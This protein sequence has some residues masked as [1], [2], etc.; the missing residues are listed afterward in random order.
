MET[1]INIIE[2]ATTNKVLVETQF[3]RFVKA[4]AKQG[5]SK[6][7]KSTNTSTT[8][9]IVDLVSTP[10]PPYPTQITQEYNPQVPTISPVNICKNAMPKTLKRRFDQD[11]D[12]QAYIENLLKL[13][14]PIQRIT[15]K[16]PLIEVSGSR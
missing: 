12:F 9:N 11:G 3:R 5:R 14:T 16:C 4:G 2:D 6:K 7:V 8:G 13:L 10:P 1:V 15:T